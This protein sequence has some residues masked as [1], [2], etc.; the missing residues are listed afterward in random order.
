MTVLRAWTIFRGEGD[1]GMLAVADWW[2]GARR[3]ARA[4]SDALVFDCL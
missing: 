1:P 2:M 4:V 3:S